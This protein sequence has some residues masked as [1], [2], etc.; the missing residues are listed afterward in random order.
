[1]S[2]LSWAEFPTVYQFADR[3]KI[4]WNLGNTM[5]SVLNVNLKFLGGPGA[6][7]QTS[8]DSV[9]AAGFNTVRLPVAWFHHSDIITSVID[10]N[11]LPA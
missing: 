3:M 7:T 9:K 4:G 2:M 5:D 11:W 1:M 10:N 8:I 6:T